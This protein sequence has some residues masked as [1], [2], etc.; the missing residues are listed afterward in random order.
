M[1]NTDSVVGDLVTDAQLEDSNQD[2]MD[3]K[4][5]KDLEEYKELDEK[6]IDFN[7]QME[8]LQKQFDAGLSLLDNDKPLD[9]KDL[10]KVMK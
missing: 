1:M 9:P 4:N 10:E 3:L 2:G 7:G 5:I 8:N 6:V